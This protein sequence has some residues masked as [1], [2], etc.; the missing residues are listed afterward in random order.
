MSP[1]K[2]R[3][4]FVAS[5]TCLLFIYVKAPSGKP[6]CRLWRSHVIYVVQ[7]CTSTSDWDSVRRNRLKPITIP[8]YKNKQYLGQSTKKCPKYCVYIRKIIDSTDSIRRREF[9]LDM[10]ISSVDIGSFNS[11]N[12]YSAAYL[13]RTRIIWNLSLTLMRIQPCRYIGN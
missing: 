4:R 6:E 13:N 11:Y 3:S 2:G 9:F 5:L 1:I 8:L 12:P 10:T 7:L